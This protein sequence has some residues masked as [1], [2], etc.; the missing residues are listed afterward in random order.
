[1][2]MP[3]ITKSRHGGT[4]VSELEKGTRILQIVHSK[5]CHVGN[6]CLDHR[7]GL[8]T[9]HMCQ[10]N[11]LTNIFILHFTFS[12]EKLPVGLMFHTVL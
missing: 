12:W 6:N 2:Q 9:D 4:N 8:N 5:I 7:T 3:M 1:M 11:P 10:S